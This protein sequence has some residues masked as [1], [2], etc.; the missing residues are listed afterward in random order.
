MPPRKLKRCSNCQL[1]LTP[2]YNFCPRCG[3]E[4]N[5]QNVSLRILLA[6]FFQNYLSFESKLFVTTG[7]LFRYPGRVTRAFNTGQRRKYMHPVRLYLLCSLLY[8]IIVSWT[9][10]GFFPKHIVSFQPTE[11][12]LADSIDFGDMPVGD[13]GMIT[14][15]MTDK[16]TVT[17]GLGLTYFNR[18]KYAQFMNPLVSDDSIF[19]VGNDEYVSGA[20]RLTMRQFRRLLQKDAEVFVPYLLK[21]VPLLIFLLMPIFAFMLKLLYV[22]K[23]RH[24]YVQHMVHT[25]HLHAQVFLVLS[26]IFLANTIFSGFN[27]VQAY[28]ALIGFLTFSVYAWLSFKKY[29]AQGFF[30]T[31]IKFLIIG[32]LYSL[33]LIFG[34]M[35][36]FTIS[37]FVF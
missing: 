31:T 3:Q 27:Q 19:N 1:S 32:W 24:L 21:N 36:L 18:E 5:D 37:F 14:L 30:K 16:D 33:S 9:W 12:M 10:Q 25:L 7:T 15:K 4:N 28:I 6:E 2:D 20:Q 23:D 11:K 26:V 29:Y 34:L 22:R 17:N 13:D 35:M 8:F